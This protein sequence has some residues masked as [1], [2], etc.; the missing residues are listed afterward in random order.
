MRLPPL[1]ALGIPEFDGSEACSSHA[2]VRDI[3]HIAGHTVHVDRAIT[4]TEDL[5]SLEFAASSGLASI[6][7]RTFP[8]AGWFISPQVHGDQLSTA[9]L[10]NNL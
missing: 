4:E 2:N 9:F 5:Q 1:L 7:K 10:D 3:K 8:A 6:A